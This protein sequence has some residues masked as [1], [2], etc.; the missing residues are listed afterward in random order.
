[1]FRRAFLNLIPAVAALAFLLGV[2]A[3]G[4]GN[5]QSTAR[6]TDVQAHGPF[7]RAA[8]RDDAAEF[9]QNQWGDEDDTPDPVARPRICTP[10][11]PPLGPAASVGSTEQ[12]SVRP[13]APARFLPAPLRPPEQS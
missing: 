5:L 12:H 1:M 7:R 6:T 10:W 8:L 13:T 2:P 3:Q 9:T 11:M 4:A